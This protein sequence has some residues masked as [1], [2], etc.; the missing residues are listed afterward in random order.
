MQ[1][2][3]IIENSL[4]ACVSWDHGHRHSDGTSICDIY[5]KIPPLQSVPHHGDGADDDD[6]GDSDMP[7]HPDCNMSEPE[8]EVPSPRP[9]DRPTS[10][11]PARV[12]NGAHEASFVCEKNTFIEIIQ[13]TGE[14]R[15]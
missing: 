14:I 5:M 4:P 12:P 8:A 2:I 9:R 6:Q 1:I 13:P 15:S 7:P 10:R 3:M 11:T